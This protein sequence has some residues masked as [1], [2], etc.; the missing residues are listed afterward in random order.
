[1]RTLVGV[2]GILLRAATAALAAGGMAALSL[3]EEGAQDAEKGD[4]EGDDEES[5]GGH[6]PE[7]GVAGRAGL[8][9]DVGEGETDG[10]EGKGPEGG[11]EDVEVAS[12]GAYR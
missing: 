3:V 7:G 10:D 5:D 9:G 12:H 2:P 8:G 6:A 1:M 11:G 4:D